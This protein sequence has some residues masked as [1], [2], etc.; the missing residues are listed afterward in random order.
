MET[1]D[2]FIKARVVPVLFTLLLLLLLLPLPLL[3][4]NLF[5]MFVVCVVDRA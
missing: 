1:L 2:H 5:F 4:C 3:L